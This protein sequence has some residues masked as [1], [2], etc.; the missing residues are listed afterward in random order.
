MDLTG[1]VPTKQMTSMRALHL[2]SITLQAAD[3]VGL[4]FCHAFSAM[5]PNLRHLGSRSRYPKAD[6]ESHL[7]L[8]AKLTKHEISYYE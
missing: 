3:P 1:E 5:F 7:G 6:I 4:T 2:E 8:F